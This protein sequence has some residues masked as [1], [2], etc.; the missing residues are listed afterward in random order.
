MFM[1][2]GQQAEV[3][4]I[5][6]LAQFQHF[7]HFV[8]LDPAKNRARFYLLSWQASLL[9]DTALVCR[10]GRLGT[11]GRSRVI[12]IPDGAEVQPKIERLIKRRF[13]HG[14][15]VAGWD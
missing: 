5:E 2:K 7:V 1:G 10:W 11:Q 15:Q 3:I 14:Y 4:P 9:G 12:I 8:S 6:D 13:Q